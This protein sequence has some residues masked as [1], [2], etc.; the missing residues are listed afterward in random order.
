LERRRA[1]RDAALLLRRRIELC[2]SLP[3]DSL[4]RLALQARLDDIGRDSPASPAEPG[5]TTLP[6][7]IRAC[8]LRGVTPSKCMP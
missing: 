1:F 4:T 7:S 3:F 6:M 5:A 2:A 8:G